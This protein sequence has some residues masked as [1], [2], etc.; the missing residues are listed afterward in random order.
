MA[1]EKVTIKKLLDAVAKLKKFE[2]KT[3]T[4]PCTMAELERV[5]K[6]IENGEI[7][8]TDS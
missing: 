3:V 6:M 1:E 5:Q 7:F 8:K 2:P 4:I